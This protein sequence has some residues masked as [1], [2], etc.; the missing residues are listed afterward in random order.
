MAHEMPAQL[1]FGL[2]PSPQGLCRGRQP[3]RE[4]EIAKQP[5]RVEREEILAIEVLG[6]LEWA[7]QEPHVAEIE[8][9]RLRGNHVGDAQL[10]AGE[11]HFRS[12]TPAPTGQ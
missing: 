7:V 1:A 5:L 2:F 12:Q 3:G 4:A 11:G 6:M 10:G 9:R 8:G